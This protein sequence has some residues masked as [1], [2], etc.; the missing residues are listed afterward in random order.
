MNYVAIEDWE[1]LFRAVKHRL[2]CLV[3]ESGGVPAAAGAYSEYESFRSGMLEC[4]DALDQLHHS[5]AHRFGLLQP[6]DNGLGIDRVEGV[7][8]VTQ[9]SRIDQVSH[10]A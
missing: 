1:V 3:G 4:I 7:A 2:K 5:V 9:A 6:H 8:S 10:P